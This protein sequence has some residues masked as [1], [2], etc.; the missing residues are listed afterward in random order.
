M[1]AQDSV[2]HTAEAD[3]RTRGCGLATTFRAPGR[4]GRD[5]HQPARSGACRRLLPEPTARRSGQWSADEELAELA[6]IPGLAAS[7]GNR[8]LSQASQAGILDAC[9]S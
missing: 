5:V 3:W 9:L 6:R 4:G 1:G 7:P 2:R 8:G